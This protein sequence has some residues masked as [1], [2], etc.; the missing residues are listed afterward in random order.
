M[1]FDVALLQI[2]PVGNDQDKNLSIGLAN[3]QK[4]RLLGADLA[5]FPELW[6][7]GCS[8][9]PLHDEGRGDWLASAISQQS[10]F[11]QAFAELAREINLNIAIT[12]LEA[13][14]PL[15]RNSVWIFDTSGAVALKYSKVFIC[16]FGQDELSKPN[17][18][19]NELVAT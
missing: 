10:K 5:V 19:P 17:P 1:N 8:R 15:P 14:K 4:A 7:I 6:S 16:N 13:H 11:L 2:S 18:Q 9:A 12:F 3:C